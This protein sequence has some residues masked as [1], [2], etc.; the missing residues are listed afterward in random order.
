[1]SSVVIFRAGQADSSKGPG[2]A[3]AFVTALVSGPRSTSAWAW[4]TCGSLPAFRAGFRL[5]AGG[6]SRGGGGT[7]ISWLRIFLL[8]GGARFYM[9]PN[10]RSACGSRLLRKL[11]RLLGLHERPRARQTTA[12][13]PEPLFVG[14]LDRSPIG[15]VCAA[16]ARGRVLIGA[17]GFRR[18]IGSF[19][20]RLFELTF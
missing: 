16:R 2:V 13:R 11:S 5:D 18:A 12:R 10:G 14:P 17:F 3:R 4:F 19:P 8:R 9:R 1:M 7:S 6:A 15:V 20:N